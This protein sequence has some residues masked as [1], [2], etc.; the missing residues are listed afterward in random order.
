MRIPVVE[1]VEIGA[2]GGSIASLD[3][4]GRVLAGPK[5]A[6]SEPGP[7]CYGRGGLLP[8][9]TDANVLLGRIQP[10]LFAGGKMALDRAASA[11]AMTAEIGMGRPE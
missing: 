2:G 8:T 10:S 3:G 7:A 1:L 4:L 5:S 9:V 11:A 6:G